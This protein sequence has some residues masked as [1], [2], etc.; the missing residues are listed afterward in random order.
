[1]IYLIVYV[2]RVYW[3]YSRNHILDYNY[4]NICN[5]IHLKVSCLFHTKLIMNIKINFPIILGSEKIGV[6]CMV[7]K[8]SLCY[9]K[10]ETGYWAGSRYLPQSYPFV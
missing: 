4:Q 2:F 6:S 8:C 10:E 7:T 3:L 9:G 1:M 5:F